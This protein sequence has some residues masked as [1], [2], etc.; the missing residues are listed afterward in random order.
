[1][2]SSNAP[3]DK[4]GALGDVISGTFGMHAHRDWCSLLIPLFGGLYPIDLVPA[5]RIRC[6]GILGDNDFCIHKGGGRLRGIFC[7]DHDQK[8]NVLD[9]NWKAGRI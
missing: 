7:S 8:M 2:R 9:Q 5:A 1:M 6:T 4:R 3:W